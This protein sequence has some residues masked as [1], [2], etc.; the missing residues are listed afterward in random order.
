M[1]DQGLDRSDRDLPAGLVAP[2]V[3]VTTADRD[4]AHLLAAL[5]VGAWGTQPGFYGG[6]QVR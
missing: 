1:A 4:P 2:E 6:I 5:H 3:V